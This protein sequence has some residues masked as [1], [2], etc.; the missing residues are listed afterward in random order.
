ME[1]V[2]NLAEA[3]NAYGP[4]SV[5]LAF[6]VAMNGCFIWRDYSRER[7]QQKQLEQL[8]Q[9]HNEIVL[10]LLT[11]CKEAIA[12][13]KEVIKQNSTIITGIFHGR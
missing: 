3:V 7:H 2:V 13:C 11:E 1:T 5:L 4:V 10:P 6:L 9:V 12:S 8:Q